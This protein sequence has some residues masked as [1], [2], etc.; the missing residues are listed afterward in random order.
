MVEY[1]D[2]QGWVAATKGALELVKSAWAM[3]PKGEK[4]DEIEAK[5]RGA[6]EALA[7]SDTKLAKEL[8][9]RLCDCSFPPQIML[10]KEAEQAHVCPNPSCGRKSGKG[11]INRQKGSWAESRHGG[12]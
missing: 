7:K 11:S 6:E 8:G 5:I 10:W 12:I 3:L 2:I 9:M 4:R 1:Q